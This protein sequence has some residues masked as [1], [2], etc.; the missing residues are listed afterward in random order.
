MAAAERMRVMIPKNT[1]GEI[2]NDRLDLT[3]PVT[4]LFVIVSLIVLGLGKITGGASTNMF[5]MTYKNSFE[6]VLTY[7]RLFFY[8]L[9][10]PGWEQWVS[11]MLLLLLLGPALEKQYGS[12][13]F[14]LMIVITAGVVGVLHN[15]IFPKNALLGADGIL[16]MM[17]T[18]RLVSD[19][20]ED[21]FP[22]TTV[23]FV[24]VFV[25]GELTGGFEKSW[26][27]LINFVGGICGIAFGMIL[28]RQSLEKRLTEQETTT[29][30]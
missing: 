4:L 9:G 30:E 13:R 26:S 8:I 18:L 3:A 15:C 12:G 22:V 1:E 2:P 19:V 10:S 29:F 24:I 28:N 17:V 5:F 27:Q 7:I 11:S 16:F 20:N 14:L 21:V 23:A 25:L 6:E